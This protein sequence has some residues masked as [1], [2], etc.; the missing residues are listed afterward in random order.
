VV[1]VDL[2]TRQLDT[3]AFVK[4]SRPNVQSFRRT[5]RAH[6][7][8]STVT[9]PLPEVDEWTVLRDG[10]IA[11]VRGRD[12]HVDLIGA[13][14]ARVAAPKMPHDW[15]RLTDEAKV[16]FLDSTRTAMAR[17]RAAMEAA[18]GGAFRVT[19]GGGAGA[20][21]PSGGGTPQMTIVMGGPGGG[22]DGPPRRGGAGSG[23]RAA[24]R[25]WRSTSSPRASS[26]TTSRPS[27]RAPRAPTPTATSGCASSPPSRSRSALRRH[28]PHRHARRARAAPRQLGDR[29][30]RPG[31]RGVPRRARSGAGCAHRHASRHAE[32]TAG[33]R[34][35]ALFGG[36]G[37]RL[38]RASVR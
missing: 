29:R 32:R 36:A 20:P 9:H 12:Y 27:G 35:A 10:T 3:A 18:G 21:P 11:I 8:V 13:D 6:D 30:L 23:P 25:I 34:C 5:P 15:Q 33:H 14:G 19:M 28:R 37:L 4:V 7:T 31:W 2:A 16:A 17:Q 26:P 22:P 24:R 38:V 1:R